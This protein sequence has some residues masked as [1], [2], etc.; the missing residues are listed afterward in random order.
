M[1]RGAIVVAVVVSGCS[2]PYQR[3]GFRGG[4]E[5]SSAGGNTHVVHVSVN[6]F[7]SQGRAISYAYQRANELCPTGYTLVDRASDSSS[8]YTRIGDSVMEMRKP[9]VTIVVRC[10]DP[11][12]QAFARVDIPRPSQSDLPVDLVQ[13]WWCTSAPGYDAGS[14]DRHRENCEAMRAA[15][16][17]TGIALDPCYEQHPVYCY[18]VQI[19]G[20]L[21]GGSCTP[22]E[23]DCLRSR[24]QTTG[25]P[26]SACARVP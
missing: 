18:D 10:N 9:E 11:A 21:V 19:P 25:I 8:T 13:R 5:D 3:M 6:A 23:R 12:P 14:C 15:M 17:Q 7:T 4:Y 16:S 20:G 26:L 1:M 22:T 24:E 2:T